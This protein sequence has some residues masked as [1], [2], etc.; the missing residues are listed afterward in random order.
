MLPRD[1]ADLDADNA[2][3]VFL[4]ARFC[5]MPGYASFPQR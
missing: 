4:R 3:S 5:V 1:V 2:I